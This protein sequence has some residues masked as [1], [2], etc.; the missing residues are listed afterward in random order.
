MTKVID[1]KIVTQMNGAV[2]NNGYFVVRGPCKRIDLDEMRHDGAFPY[3][4]NPQARHESSKFVPDTRGRTPE[5]W[6]LLLPRGVGSSETMMLGL[7]W[8]SFWNLG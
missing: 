5:H 8:G 1:G 4:H 3:Q 7:M 2:E 6:A